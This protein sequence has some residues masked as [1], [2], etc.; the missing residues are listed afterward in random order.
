MIIGDDKLRLI[1][2]QSAMPYPADSIQFR[3][4]FL[5]A[6]NGNTPLPVAVLSE[7][8]GQDGK[9]IHNA[10]RHPVNHGHLIR[11]K[12][13]EFWKFSLPKEPRKLASKPSVKPPVAEKAPEVAVAPKPKAEPEPVKHYPNGIS[14]DPRDIASDPDGKLIS[15]PSEPLIGYRK[16]QPI[17]D[18]MMELVDR[19]GSEFDR[20]DPRA[21]EHL[22]VYAPVVA[23]ATEPPACDFG[24]QWC[25]RDGFSVSKGG[26]TLNL[27]EP[28][29]DTL[30]RL[31]V[32]MRGGLPK[33]NIEETVQ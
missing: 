13:G 19:L 9:T 22:L 21:W 14:R 30:L 3:T 16:A 6:E 32:H 28:E 7:C 25:S 20:V 24:A 10:L 33:L 15:D 12:D 23:Q 17:S 29:L 1:A 18:A 5:L 27:T 11:E 26:S 2:E 8:L 31:Y 4:I